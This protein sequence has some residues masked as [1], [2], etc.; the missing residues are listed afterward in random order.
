MRLK[1]ISHNLCMW[2]H[3][4]PYNNSSIINLLSH[5][6]FIIVSLPLPS[7]TIVTHAPLIYA[8]VVNLSVVTL[9][10]GP[11][12]PAI[13]FCFKGTFNILS[14]LTLEVKYASHRDCPYILLHYILWGLSCVH[15]EFFRYIFPKFMNFY[16]KL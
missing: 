9:Q 12:P 4:M 1:L 2:A 10:D 5:N 13:E 15:E 11:A 14:S 3:H 6:I 7:V 16:K 8:D